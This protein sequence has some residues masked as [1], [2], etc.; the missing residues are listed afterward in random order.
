[1]KKVFVVTSP[2]KILLNH[3]SNHFLR[4]YNILPYGKKSHSKRFRSNSFDI[5]NSRDYCGLIALK[6]NSNPTADSNLNFLTYLL[7]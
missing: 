3:L 2:A 5:A 6:Y 7:S 4:Q 1:M